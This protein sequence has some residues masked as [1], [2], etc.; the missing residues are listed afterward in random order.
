M[1]VESPRL[2]LRSVE[3]GDLDALHDLDNDPEVMKW[4]NG[5]LPVSR[6]YMETEI[7]PLF[8]QYDE[9]N[10]VLGFWIVEEIRTGNFAGWVSLRAT[11]DESEASLGYRFV[12]QCWGRG[13]ATEAS[14]ALLHTAFES[15][16]LKSVR[17]STYE[18]NI[19][20]QVVMKRL[21]MTHRR[22]YRLEP[23]ELGDTSLS[24]EEVWDGD[25][26]EFAVS[27]DA[28]IDFLSSSVS[29]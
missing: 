17:A 6:D 26:V 1:L 19:G 22:S 23:E 16:R 3:P 20:S 7:L 8:M 9:D 29:G 14:L 15:S 10:P 24:G 13:F 4:I 18:E 28:F 25:E 21:G 12:R 2:R 11:D 27:R 5:G